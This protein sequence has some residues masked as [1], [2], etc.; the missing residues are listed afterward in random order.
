MTAPGLATEMGH[1]WQK[2]FVCV[3][4]YDVISSTK[5]SEQHNLNLNDTWLGTIHFI[6][7]LIKCVVPT[8]C[9]VNNEYI[10]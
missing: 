10:E 2:I 9:N 3:M 5:E 6:N 8:R 4:T 1:T 7:E